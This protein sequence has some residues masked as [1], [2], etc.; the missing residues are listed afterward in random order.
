[1]ITKL[2]VYPCRHCGS[3]N[4]VK[5]GHNGSGSP[6]YKCKDCG[7]YCVLEP[8]RGYSKAKKEEILAA[9]HERPSM[10]GIQRIFG[11]SP[12]TLATWL[13]KRPE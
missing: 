4:I 10:R 7:K 11:V 8:K 1:M 9:Y 5:N 13:K 3:K 2:V 12:Q 6:Q